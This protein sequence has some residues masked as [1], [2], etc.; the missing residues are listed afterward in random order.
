[1]QI[2]TDDEVREI[3]TLA[4]SRGAMH[5]AT[6]LKTINRLL[7][8][9]FSLSLERYKPDSNCG[10]LKRQIVD[11][12]PLHETKLFNQ[13]MVLLTDSRRVNHMFF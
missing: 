10:I 4:M 5:W 2:A 6:L 3:E 9:H 1:M 8:D 12:V 13:R 11:G 7:E